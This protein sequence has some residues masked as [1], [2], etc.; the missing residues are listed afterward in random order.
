MYV[1]LDILNHL[2]PY[3]LFFTNHQKKFKIKKNVKRSLRQKKYIHFFIIPCFESLLKK[4]TNQC[5]LR[6]WVVLKF[7]CREMT[8]LHCALQ[9]TLYL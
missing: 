4:T 8:I 2:V 5:L 6:Y 1:V 7:Y 9:I 3:L